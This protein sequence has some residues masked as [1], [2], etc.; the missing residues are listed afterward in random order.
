MM[1]RRKKK[2]ILKEVH[3]IIILIYQNISIMITTEMNPNS[4]ELNNRI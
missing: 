2:K 3:M 1:K 4:T